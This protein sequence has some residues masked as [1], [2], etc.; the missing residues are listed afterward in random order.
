MSRVVGFAA[1]NM[2]FASELLV[3]RL[4]RRAHLI[5]WLIRRRVGGPA[6]NLTVG[7]SY[8]IRLERRRGFGVGLAIQTNECGMA[9][10]NPNG[11]SI[12][13]KLAERAV[14]IYDTGTKAIKLPPRLAL[15]KRSNVFFFM[16]LK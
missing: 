11:T 14:T 4:E 6:D 12:L 5:R 16:G 13:P 8:D 3:A 1:L 9:P 2:A 15:Q 10:F 7:E